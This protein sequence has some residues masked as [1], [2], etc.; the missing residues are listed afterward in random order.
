M[1]PMK[2]KTFIILFNLLALVIGISYI[3]I[4]AWLK[5]DIT[6]I[7]MHATH[8]YQEDKVKALLL[9]IQDEN[10]SLDEKNRAIWALGKLRDKRAIPVLK[11]LQT[12]KTCDHKNNVCQRELEKAILTLEG[13]SIDLFT[14]K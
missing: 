4:R 12:G 8:L 13:E 5:S 1:I 11:E 9:L 3:S 6:E 10:I 7:C 2:P 14:Y